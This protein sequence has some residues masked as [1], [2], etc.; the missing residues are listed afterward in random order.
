MSK[1]NTF[2]LPQTLFD[3]GE[4]SKPL[5]PTESETSRLSNY[6]FRSGQP[7]VPLNLPISRDLQFPS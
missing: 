7:L 3:Q 1:G 2:A 6:S 4:M 5:D